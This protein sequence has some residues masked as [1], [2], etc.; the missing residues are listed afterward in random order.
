M[1]TIAARFEAPRKTIK[2]SLVTYLFSQVLFGELKALSTKLTGAKVFVGPSLFVFIHWLYCIQSSEVLLGMGHDETEWN[3]YP[4]GSEVGEIFIPSKWGTVYSVRS[5]YHITDTS[6][7][8]FT[9]ST[10][11][12]LRWRIPLPDPRDRAKIKSEICLHFCSFTPS[13]DTNMIL[14]DIHTS[15][16]QFVCRNPQGFEPPTKT[17]PLRQR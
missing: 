3:W 12:F 8:L 2:R 13:Q 1:L 11:P 14:I 17:H 16:L 6:P 4:S 7:S 5:R 15:F 10:I 9:S